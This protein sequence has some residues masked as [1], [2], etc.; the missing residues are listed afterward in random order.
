MV[1]VLRATQRGTREGCGKERGRGESGRNGVGRS[2]EKE[3]IQQK[4]NWRG[5]ELN[6][7]KSQLSAIISF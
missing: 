4:N 1:V 3:V 6:L 7:I 2:R 5:E